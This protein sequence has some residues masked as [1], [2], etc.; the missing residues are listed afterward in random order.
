M[1]FLDNHALIEAFPPH[2]PPH[3]P[4]LS[5][6]PLCCLFSQHS[7][8]L[9][10]L[11]YYFT[12][13]SSVFPLVALGST[14]AR[15]TALLFILFPSTSTRLIWLINYWN[16]LDPF[17]VALT[18]LSTTL[19]YAPNQ[20]FCCCCEQFEDGWRFQRTVEC[21]VWATR[22]LQFSSMQGVG[23]GRMPTP[24]CVLAFLFFNKST[25]FPHARK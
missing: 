9:I 2:L 18:L 13:S 12:Y 10:L 3:T 7:L 8:N 21:G 17:G 11:I 4:S 22:I 23:G 16:K 15:A 6:I 20:C 1:S 19:A 14:R 25:I 5:I 24:H